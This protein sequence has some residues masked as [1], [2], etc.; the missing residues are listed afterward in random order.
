MSGGHHELLAEIVD[1]LG[2]ALV[3][4]R[5]LAGGSINDAF[6]LDL[7]DGRRAFVKA[8]ADADRAEFVA[9][10]AG[11]RW[12]AA[13]GTVPVPAVLGIG[14]RSAWLALEWVERGRLSSLGRERLGRGLAEIHRAGA[15]R[16]GELAP[17]VEGGLAD[18]PPRTA[19]AAG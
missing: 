3:G 13:P 18:R 12:I 17:G 15:D 9:E 1:S 10:A 14:D 6:A 5:P 4:S 19:V 11:L 16:F 7:S 2:V 8:R